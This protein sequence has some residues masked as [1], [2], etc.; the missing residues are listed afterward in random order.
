[1]APAATATADIAASPPTAELIVDGK[2]CPG[3]VG[4][5]TWGAYSQSAPWH[6]AT[7]LSPLTIPADVALAAGLEGRGASI[8]SWTARIAAAADT[9]G[10]EAVPLG[11]GGATVA[12]DGPPAGEWVLELRL[13]FAD[14]AGDGA[15]YWH[16]VVP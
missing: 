13:V 1:V 6:L 14:G 16:L 2:R 11:S 3:T 15:W 5:Y 7:G 12:F 9:T 8:D 4:G 10:N